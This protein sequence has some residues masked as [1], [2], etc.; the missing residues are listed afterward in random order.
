MIDPAVPGLLTLAFPCGHRAQALWLA[1][2]HQG[3]DLVAS[4]GLEPA[5]PT[6]VIV[7]GAG[8]MDAASMQQLQVLFNA[9]LAPLAQDLGLTVIDGGTDVGVMQLMGQ[10]RH[11]SAATFPLVGVLPQEQ[12]KVPDPA[13]MATL[14]ALQTGG[15]IAASLPKTAADDPSRSLGG[16]G[17]DYDLEPHHTHFL[18]TPGQA[19]G[20]ESVWI[21]D[22]ATA[23]S[24]PQPSLTLLINGGQI[25][26]VDFH[27]HLAAGRPVLVLAGSGRF[28]DDV[29]QALVADP[30]DIPPALR[31]VIQRYQPSGALRSLDMALSP[32]ALRQQLVTYFDP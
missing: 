14:K 13:T 22:L 12:A 1:S 31:E 15:K 28:A 19:W 23:V 9:V 10:A 5:R 7:G 24:A 18:L 30:Q 11:R 20:S 4:L 16:G 21:S 17:P 25:A 2:Q 29:A 3:L 8:L 6:L 27:L 26:A 32:Q